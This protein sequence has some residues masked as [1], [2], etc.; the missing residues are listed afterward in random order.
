MQLTPLNELEAV[1]EILAS[2]NEAPINSLENL[3]DLDA[4]NALN[5]LRRV[6]RQFQARGWSFN[7][8][9]NYVFNP[10]VYTKKIKWLDTLL[11]IKSTDGNKYIK[12]GEFFYNMTSQ[13][14]HFNAP[15][16]ANVVLLTDFA[17]MPD[18][19]KSY[20]TAK[21]CTDFSVR[22]LGDDSLGKTLLQREQEAWA[23][24]HEYEMDTNECNMLDNT[25]IADVKARK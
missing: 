25:Y 19:A 17:D 1:N 9:E 15:I 23:Y 18:A 8:F 6:N 13:T 16:Q 4:V 11:H 10:D 24:F 7:T 14:F 3:Q 21:A 2:I 5:T 20:I 12:R 22:F